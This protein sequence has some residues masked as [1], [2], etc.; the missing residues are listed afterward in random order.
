[1][2]GR[3]EKLITDEIDM[4][5]WRGQYLY[6]RKAGRKKQ[7]KRFIHKRERNRTRAELDAF[8]EDL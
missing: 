1:M 2:M 7:L 3:K 4:V 5:C 6:L 8:K